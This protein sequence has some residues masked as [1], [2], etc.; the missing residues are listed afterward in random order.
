MQ[1]REDVMSKTTEQRIARAIQA[2]TGATYTACLNA[3]RRARGNVPDGPD[4]V[5]RWAD[6]ARREFPP[7][8]KGA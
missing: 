3:V 1:Y 4:F 2:E 6:A 5:E 8:P 7:S